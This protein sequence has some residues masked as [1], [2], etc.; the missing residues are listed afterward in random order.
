MHA[1]AYLDQ[2]L[3]HGRR[4]FST[5]EAVTALG[6]SVVAVRAAL[7]RLK[8][9]GVLATP[10]R[11]FHVIVPPEHRRLGCLPAEQFLPDLM[12]H[13]HVPYYVA[14]LSAAAF[15][16]AA[17]QRPQRLQVMVSSGRRPVRCGEVHVQFLSRADAAETAVRELTTPAGY[18]RVASPEAT[19]LEL[20]G[21]AEQCGGLSHVATVLHE[22][23]PALGGQP[24]LAECRRCPIAWVQRLGYLL[25][26]LDA[27]THLQM[28]GAH[29]VEHARVVAPLVA[30]HA[31]SSVPRSERWKLDVN[32]DVEPDL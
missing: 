2:L 6:G 28:L 22:L 31:T 4:T 13:L 23:E 30:A 3:A 29:V 11:G 25:E 5:A 10:H 20:V 19:A 16:G 1:A 14:L 15:Y 18:L 12:Q 24:L 17:H 8:A 9:K 21:Y 26:R 27:P 7:R 32:A